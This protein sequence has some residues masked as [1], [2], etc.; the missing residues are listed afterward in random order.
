[1]ARGTQC[2]NLFLEFGCPCTC[3]G[4]GV[5]RTHR[6]KASPQRKIRANQTLPS[7]LSVDQVCLKNH[8]L[9]TLPVLP[10]VVASRAISTN[11]S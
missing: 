5:H 9:E 10:R 2:L 7:Q 4:G 11:V 8:S 1:M 6:G 3:V